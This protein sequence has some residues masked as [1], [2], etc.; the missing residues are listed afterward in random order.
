MLTR[1]AAFS[2]PADVIR[3]VCTWD[4]RQLSQD[5]LMLLMQVNT[6]INFEHPWFIGHIPFTADFD[7]RPSRI[8][9]HVYQAFSALWHML[10]CKVRGIPMGPLACARACLV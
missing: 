4:D 10:E 2:G 6:Y 1:F 9:Q 5:Q 8:S 7:E 3:L